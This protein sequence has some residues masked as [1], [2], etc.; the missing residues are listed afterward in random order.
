[1]KNS[2]LLFLVL[3]FLP[4]LINCEA[5]SGNLISKTV[6]NIPDIEIIS[7]TKTSMNEPSLEDLCRKIT[8]TP[9]GLTCYFKHIYNCPKYA[10]ELLPSLP[11]K[12]LQEF[13]VHGI[14]TNQPRTYTKAVFRLFEK[15]F[16]AAPYIN[17]E[18]M[19][20]FLQKLPE[21]LENCLAADLN[22]K[23]LIKN[24]IRFELE[25]NFEELKNNPDS[26]LDNL[27]GKINDSET[28]GEDISCAKLRMYIIK[29]L[30]VCLN[31][32]VWSPSDEHNVWTSFIK[33]GEELNTLKN[34]GIVI[35]NDDLDDCQWTLTTRF[36]L[37]LSLSGSDLPLSFYE[38]ARDDIHKG[39]SHLTSL[40]EQEELITTKQNY[41][42]DAII[43]SAA[44]SNARQ[45]FGIL[46]E[47]V[48]VDA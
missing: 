7:I 19:V 29:F 38:K 13:L 31:K 11:F 14:N 46:S 43:E 32:I 27:A 21:L 22:K 12:H 24:L 26:F 41:L 23:S 35:D 45:K 44:K 18:E 37:F 2:S 16:K 4:Q 6:T 17:A 30:D 40:E 3:L 39:V 9:S 34:K 28:C 10:H 5:V 47:D 1:M 33:I 42:Q 20:P 15:K 25:H 8:F 36:C 48:L